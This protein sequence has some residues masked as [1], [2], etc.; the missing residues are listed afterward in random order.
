M[1]QFCP[2]AQ[3]TWLVLLEKG[4]HPHTASTPEHIGTR[5]LPVLLSATAL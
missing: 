4:V 5:Q 1:L 2:F 3:R